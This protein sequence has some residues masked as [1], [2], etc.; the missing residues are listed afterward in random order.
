MKVGKK[1][2]LGMVLF[3]FVS[4]LSANPV[5]EQVKAGQASFTRSGSKLIIQQG[6]ERVI[7]NWQD[8]SIANGELTKFIQPSSSSAALNKVI[9]GNPSA[10]FGTLKANGQIYL[11]NPNGIVVGKSGVINTQSFIASTLNVSNIEFMNGGDLHFVGDS[12]AMVINMGSIDAIGGDV[13]LIAHKVENKG[14]IKAADGSVGLAGGT[15]VLL[16]TS[17]DNRLSVRLTAQGGSVESKGIIE[18]AQVELKAEGNNPYAL[19]INHSGLIRANGTSNRG[20]RVILSSA[21]GVTDVSGEI[22]AEAN[23]GNAGI[24]TLYSEDTMRFTGHV[25][26]LEQGEVHISGKEKLVFEG[27]VDTEGGTLI[28]DPNNVEITSGAATLTGASTISASALTA[29]LG[30]NNVIVH[31]SGADGEDGDIRISEALAYSSSNDLSFLAHRHI[32]ANETISLNGDNAVLNL[33]AGWDGV[34]GF[35]STPGSGSE[36]GILN[37]AAIQADA[38]SYGNSGG[39]ITAHSIAGTGI[40][41]SINFYAESITLLSTIATSGNF[42]LGTTVTAG[43]ITVGVGGAITAGGGVITVGGG[44][45]T[46]GGAIITGGGGTISPVI[47]P[48]ITGRIVLDIPEIDIPEIVTAGQKTFNNFQA[49]LSN[50]IASGHRQ[51]FHGGYSLTN[52]ANAGNHITVGDIEPLPWLSLSSASSLDD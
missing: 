22:V 38:G 48:T 39:S 23:A 9:S 25:E 14:I 2:Y 28:L 33:V 8:F 10:I 30:S 35:T 4:G 42:T 31:T 41:N 49:S 44:A 34:T 16:K 27:T 26:S 40:D 3:A 20:G 7:I 18:A 45:I 36:T 1:I 47:S 24:V 19:A 12:D 17:G 13:F 43:G 46:G 32:E 37:L 21:Q 29:A 5:G 15:E 52:F 6:T 11:I 50:E 51:P